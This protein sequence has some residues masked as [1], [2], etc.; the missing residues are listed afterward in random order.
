MKITTLLE[1][2]SAPGR[3]GLA[4]E[5]GL[6]F[7]VQHQGH[8]FMSDVGKSGKFADNAPQ[9]GCDLEAVEALAISH[10]HYDHGGGLE[11]F[12]EENDRAQVYLKSAPQADYVVETMGLPVRYVGLDQ[13]VLQKHAGRITRIET[14][15]EVLP[16]VH[17]LT[18]I[19]KT[20][21]RPSG[22]QRLKMKTPR[23]TTRDTFAHELTTVLDAAD[24]LVILTGCAHTGVLNMITAARQ[25][26]PNRPLRAVIGG[27]HLMRENPAVVRQIGET[28]LEMDVPEVHTGHCTGERSTGVLAEVL[29]ERLHTLGTGAVYTY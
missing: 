27:F 3:E 4:V 7:Y 12:F 20:Y 26:F 11:R 10:H 15:R 5:H 9:L 13:E 22:D 1:N 19:T 28:L 17:L 23:G 2:T 25:T 14:S 16:G 21:P 29:G 6:S 24:G 18:E 8:F